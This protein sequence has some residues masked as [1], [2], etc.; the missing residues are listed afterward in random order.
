MG[1][2]SAANGSVF[3]AGCVAQKRREVVETEV[4]DA[5]GS[6]VRRLHEFDSRQASVDR[7]ADDQR[8][9]K[10]ERILSFAAEKK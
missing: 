7:L 9:E 10:V 6:D 5:V 4:S 2:R 1:L 3:I 8:E